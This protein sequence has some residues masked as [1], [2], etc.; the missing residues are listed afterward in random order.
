MNSATTHLIRKLEA[1]G[2]L[3]ETERRGIEEL[4]LVT[5]LVPSGHEIVAD[6]STPSHCCLIIS[7]WACRHKTLADG[8]RQIL[9]FHIPGDMPDLQS[10]HLKVMDHGLTSVSD[11]TAAF[12]PHEHVRRLIAQHPGIGALLWRDTL[13]DASMFREWM[14]NMGRRSALERA[15]HLFCEMYMKMRAVA[16]AGE[17]RFPLPLTQSDLS[18]ALGLSA[19]HTNRILQD[20]RALGLITLKSRELDILDWEGLKALAGFDPTYLHLKAPPGLEA[21]SVQRQ[22]GAA[23]G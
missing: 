8:Q 13:I 12:T 22:S 17:S 20:M 4:S 1:I 2:N 21:A 6:G 10:L 15:A 23:V 18:D 19:V 11:C 9:S 16:L 7:G 5:R 3:T 14:V